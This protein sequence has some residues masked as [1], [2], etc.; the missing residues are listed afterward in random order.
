MDLAQE[1]AIHFNVYIVS[2]LAAF[3]VYTVLWL[4][5]NVCSFDTHLE[6]PKEPGTICLERP[7]RP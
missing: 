7:N 5:R 1:T 4:Q 2:K 6:R 3:W